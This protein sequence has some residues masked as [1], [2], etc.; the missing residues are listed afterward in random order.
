MNPMEEA[1]GLKE[2]IGR[3]DLT[4]EQAGEKVGRSGA[5]V[6]TRV[7][8]LE[9]PSRVQEM[10]EKGRLSPSN[11]IELL[12]YVGT[13]SESFLVRAAEVGCWRGSNQAFKSAL[14]AGLPRSH[15]K[16][17]E[18][19]TGCFC[20]CKCCLNFGHHL[21]G[22]RPPRVLAAE[23]LPVRVEVVPAEASDVVRALSMHFD[24][25]SDLLVASQLRPIPLA[26]I[27]RWLS[28]AYRLMDYPRPKAGPD[29]R[30]V[31]AFAGLGEEG[32]LR[33]AGRILREIAA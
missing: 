14:E 3:C 20:K 21:R 4:Q 13:T 24:G 29:G 28:A 31:V 30:A 8:F 2:Y 9:L 18:A 23:D 11:A 16:K 1:R 6:S 5:W 10:I 7:R 12:P 33:V 17:I 15:P 22:H 32:R 19:S 25:R 27:R 26:E